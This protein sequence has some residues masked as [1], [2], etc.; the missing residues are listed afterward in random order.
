M[1]GS[2]RQGCR[3][4]IQPTSRWVTVCQFVWCDMLQPRA[5]CSLAVP[6]ALGTPSCPTWLVWELP[7][8]LHLCW[9]CPA[10]H[11]NHGSPT[12]TTVSPQLESKA[13]KGITERALP[14]WKVALK[15]EREEHQHL[16]AESYSAVMDLT[17]QLQINEKNWNQEKVE[18]LTRFKEEQQQAEQQVKDLQNKVNQVWC[19]PMVNMSSSLCCLPPMLA[20]SA[21]MAAWGASGRC[22][23]LPGGAHVAPVE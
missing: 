8:A 3:Q 11:W 5:G 14:D 18:L 13:G 19:P 6:M 10:P 2:S 7:T 17:K 15:R 23:C 9:G 16:L 20:P 12:A 21:L 1:P 4:D 22:F